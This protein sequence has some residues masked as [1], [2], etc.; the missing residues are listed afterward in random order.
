M[1]EL[2][3]MPVAKEIA[4]QAAIEVEKLKEKGIRNGEDERKLR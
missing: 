2:R 3:G 4:G 1:Q